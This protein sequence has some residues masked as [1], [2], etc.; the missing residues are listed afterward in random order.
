[1]SDHAHRTGKCEASGAETNV[2]LD[3]V[4]RKFSHKTVI[5]GLA[6]W[7]STHIAGGGYVYVS[8]RCLPERDAHND[9]IR[10]CVNPVLALYLFPGLILLHGD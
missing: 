7:G 2:E 4:A 1:M 10:V 3:Q 8:G 5:K 6:T 9:K